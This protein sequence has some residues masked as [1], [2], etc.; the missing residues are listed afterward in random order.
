M[1]LKEHLLD[2]HPHTRSKEPL[3]EVRGVVIHWVQWPGASAQK[4]RDYFNSLPTTE[5][6]RYASAH[7]A[8][9]LAGEIIKMI[10]ENECAWHA[11][12]SSKTVASVEEALGGKPNWRTIGIEMC[13]PGR[14]GAFLRSTWRSAA[15]LTA[16][17]MR[18]YDISPGRVYRHFDCTGKECPK[19]FVD[20]NEE[21]T[22]FLSDVY[23]RM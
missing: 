5:P 4:I 17:I 13:H 9:G 2:V 6:S 20:H 8:V 22:V 11:G 16:T 21:W 14:D 23:S 12:P 10:P 18:Q 15:M 3:K 1:N 19:W 7:Y